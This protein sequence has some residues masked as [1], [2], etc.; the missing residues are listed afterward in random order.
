MN[1]PPSGRV[2][3][4]R[5]LHCGSSPGHVH[6]FTFIEL[7]VVIT[8]LG[9]LSVFAMPGWFAMSRM[10][11]DVTRRRLATDLTYARE[12]A[13]QKHDPVMVK[14]NT[15]AGSYVIYQRSTG[16]DLTDPSN[17]SR[18]LSFTMNGQ[19]NS[20]GVTLTSAAIGGMA[21]MRFN[22]WGTPCDSLGNAIT[23]TGIVVLASGGNS[24][25][26]RVE[27]RTGFVR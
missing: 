17:R 27:A 4:R 14:F 5:L 16:V 10:N 12:V 26:V 11:L 1:A 20:G 2:R 3:S 24:D 23:S 18:T 9:V 13:I 25:T 15:A 19:D 22:S 7:V 8:I 6:G 21:G